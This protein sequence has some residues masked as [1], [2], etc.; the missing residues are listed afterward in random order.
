MKRIAI[1]TSGGDAPGMNAAIRAATLTAV[2]AGCEVFGVKRG[3]QGLLTGEITELTSIVVSDILHRGGTVLRSARSKE[4]K[5]E[6][7]RE[8]AVQQLHNYGIEGIVVIGGDGSFRG[9][10]E[11]ANLGFA[12]VGIPGTIDNDIECTDLSIGFDTALNTVLDSINKIRDTAVSHDR[13]YVVEVMGKNSGFIA[14]YAGLAGGADAVLIPEVEPNLDQVVQRIETVNRTG[15]RHCIVLVAEG[16]FG[17]PLSGRAFSESAAFKVATYINLKI[18]KDTRVTI[19]GHIQRGGSP[20]ALDRTLG[21]RFGA[22]AVELLLAGENRKM[23]GWVDHDLK[24]SPMDDAIARKKRIE[25]EVY[26][27]VETLA[28]I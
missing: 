12:T 18:K 17:D 26:A 20:S 15:R 1:I 14:L 27:L 2:K 22:K 8:K 16:I 7:G 23:V 24:V 25:P 13:V 9:G 4:F 5:T 19:L 28:S 6:E 10:L 21:T 3:Y 11:L